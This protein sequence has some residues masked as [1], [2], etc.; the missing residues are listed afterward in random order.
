MLD[1]IV[2]LKTDLQEDDL[3]TW[4]WL[5][6]LI[7]ALGESGMSSEES[8]VENGVENVLRVKNMEWRRNI[9][10]EL[11][12]VDLQRIIDSDI[13]SQRGSRPLIQKRAHGNPTTT[14][15]A[16]T[17]LPLALYDGAWMANL[18]ERQ[19]EALEISQEPFSWVRV[20]VA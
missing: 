7:K 3:T 4:Q 15:K 17:G 11:E 14:R 10:R 20:I 18:T 16:L 5:Q 9:D 12:I 1:H 13:F 8:S 6:A 2:A 19:L